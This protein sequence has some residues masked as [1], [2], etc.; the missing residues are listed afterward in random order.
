M[1]KTIVF[2]V[3]AVM[4][5]RA[6]AGFEVISPESPSMPERT[7]AAELQHYLGK[8]ARDIVVD[9][10]HDVVFHVGDTAFARSNGIDCGKME[11]EAWLVKSFGGQ[12]VMAGGGTRGTL[13]AVY[14]FLEN[15]LGVHWWTHWDHDYAPPAANLEFG[16]LDDSGKPGFKMR[17]VYRYDPFF[18]NGQFSARNRCNCET[19]YFVGAEFGG[20][21]RYGSPYH[22]HT[23]GLYL[24][25]DKYF[26]AHPEYFAMDKAGKRVSSQLCVSN[27]ALR[28]LLLEK[29]LCNIA[30]DKALAKAKGVPA[31]AVYDLSINDNWSQC[32]CPECSAIT[33]ADNAS[34]LHLRLVNYLADEVKTLHP[35]ITLEM[36]AYYYTEEP[37]KLTRPHDNVA[38]RLC[39]TRSN[40][41]FG[42]GHPDN[43]L[44]RGLVECWGKLGTVH[45]WG[46]AFTD[47]S[48]RGLPYPSEYSFAETHRFYAANRV[49]GMFW[50]G[51]N[52]VWGDMYPLKYWLQHKFMENPCADFKALHDTFMAGYYGKA[53]PFLSRYRETLGAAAERNRL[54]YLTYDCGS[55]AFQYIDLDT[56]L[57][58]QRLCDQ[59]E[60]AVAGDAELL[61]RVRHARLSL[62]RQLAAV[63]TFFY[64]GEWARRGGK[65]SEFP[66]DLEAARARIVRTWRDIGELNHYDEE[67]YRTNRAKGYWQ[68]QATLERDIA[69]QRGIERKGY[70]PPEGFASRPYLEFLAPNYRWAVPSGLSLATDSEADLGQVMRIDAAD[71]RTMGYP[72]PVAFHGLT[73]KGVHPGLRI[74][75]DDVPGPGYHW[76][77]IGPVELLDHGYLYFTRSWG[78]QAPMGPFRNTF[79]GKP[80]MINVR[81][82]FE[83]Q[84]YFPEQRDKPNAIYVER[85]V[86]VEADGKDMSDAAMLSGWRSSGSG[87]KRAGED[88]ATV[89]DGSLLLINNRLVRIDK[90]K[91]YRISGKFKQAP[92]M[93]PASFH[94]GATMLTEPGWRE[95]MACNVNVV[96]GTT[97]KLLED[98]KAHGLKAKIGPLGKTPVKGQFLA[99]G[100]EASLAD[101]PNFKTSEIL[102]AARCDGGYELTLTRGP[103]A[104]CLRGLAVRLHNPGG[105]LY[106][107]AGEAP[108]TWREY[109]GVVGGEAL[110]G[111]PAQAWWRGAAYA[112]LLVL[113]DGKP[114]QALMF[115]EVRIDVVE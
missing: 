12:V 56:M 10:K 83:G 77:R 79:G 7:A 11:D 23:Y 107:A 76:Y 28:L 59:A 99:F 34:G 42:P 112:Q 87:G 62:D 91:R 80:V 66:V 97:T 111:N 65:A 52:P 85:V 54:S 35:D 105:Y 50:Q 55:G 1:V 26:A 40:L 108:G 82:K 113:V 9:G 72:V 4:A 37:P 115:K 24:P 16:K 98:L 18:D 96:P 6:S 68:E 57:E 29:L 106:A 93:T 20:N 27:P 109:C 61:M 86:V 36:L 102:D 92:G 2:A 100:A 103:D 46:Y 94:L 49:E 95:V 88:G 39:D 75:R 58:S 69:F 43:A 30:R 70:I 64:L 45:V 60:R 67:K 78:L 3:F 19:E 48:A 114:G 25:T 73:K 38:V 44:F 104:E 14:N 17:E 53:G 33:Q 81:M 31:P 32:Q 22:V 90:D 89:V 110:C 51:D 84:G 13:Y 47:F 8:T 74:D 71:Q 21:H 41:L 15:R 101:L 63:N 5:M